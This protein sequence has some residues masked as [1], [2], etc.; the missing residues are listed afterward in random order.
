MYKTNVRIADINVEFNT[1]YYKLS[2]L[3]KD[4]LFENSKPEIVINVTQEEID[5]ELANAHES[6]ILP[7]F[8][9]AACACRAFCNEI[10]KY[11]AILFHSSVVDIN[12]RA[13]AFAA[14][15][16]VG[17]TTHTLLWKRLL[18]DNLTIINGDKPI[19]RFFDK[20]PFA[21]G[22]PWKGKE[23]FGTNGKS[24][25]T[26]I[27]FIER[28]R[29][30]SATKMKKENALDRIFNQVF[31]PH[32]PSGTT[33][34]LKLIDM[35]LTECNLWLIKCNTD[36]SAAEVAYNTIFARKEENETNL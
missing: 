4:F 20:V 25:L 21:Y 35:M 30:N 31:L 2:S 6:I 22:T 14:K 11:D 33:K 7:S 32:D 1:K 10:W 34:T 16:G 9:E 17:K 18:G 12:G 13:V 5:R 3:S 15:S 19:V 27:C 8:C 36:I 23:T 29:N 24:N 26:D 28:N